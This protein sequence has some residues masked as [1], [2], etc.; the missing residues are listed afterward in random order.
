MSTFSS[1]LMGAVYRE[2]TLINFITSI[3][4]SLD[5]DV[6]E[7]AI[8]G[9]EYKIK[10]V[11]AYGAEFSGSALVDIDSKQLLDAALAESTTTENWAIYPD[12]T[13]L[14]NYWY[15]EGQLNAWSTTGESGGLWSGDFAGIVAG[16][17]SVVGFETGVASASAS[18]SGSASASPSS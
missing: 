17:L 8:M 10:R 7:E 13:D 16:E 2:G 11:G 12:R 14:T 4:L 3:S 6:A 9:Q 1:G 5:R 15:F 18:A